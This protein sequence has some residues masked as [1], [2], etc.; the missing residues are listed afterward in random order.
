[1]SCY[2]FDLKKPV[3]I[4]IIIIFCQ[5]KFFKGDDNILNSFNYLYPNCIEL[6][7]GNFLIIFSD[8]VYIF[9]TDISEEINKIEYESGFSLNGGDDMNLINLAKFDDGIIIAIIKIYLY[10]FSSNGNYIHHIN[11]NDDINGAIYYSLIPIK[12]EE[13]NYYF[14]ITFMD[15]STKISIYYY[16]INISSNTYETIKYLQYSDSSNEMTNNMGLTCLLMKPSKTE[17]EIVCFYKVNGGLGATSFKFD[18]SINVSFNSVSLNY[19]NKGYYKSAANSDKTKALICRSNDGAGGYCI[20]YDITKNSFS[21]DIKYFNVCGNIPRGIHID[22]FE[23]TK[24]FIF[25]C[26]N[27]GIAISIIKFDSDGNVIG[28]KKL[29][30]ETNYYFIGTGLFSYTIIFLSKYSQYSILYSAN[31]VKSYHCLFSEEFKPSHI[32]GA[33]EDTDGNNFITEITLSELYIG[34][35]NF[36][37]QITENVPII[38]TTNIDSSFISEEAISTGYSDIKEAITENYS[39]NEPNNITSSF[40]SEIATSNKYSDIKKIVTENYSTDLL[41][42]NTSSPSSSSILEETTSI[43]YSNI[44]EI[45]TEKFSTNISTSITPSFISEEPSLINSV[46]IESDSRSSI[47]SKLTSKIIEVTDTDIINEQEECSKFLNGDIKCLYCNEESLKLNKC[48]ECNTE[49]GYYPISYKEKDE[50]YIECYNN[51]SKLNN[52][53][54]DSKSFML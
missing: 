27:T 37:T 4:V 38:K 42:N 17:K 13:N 20:I 33:N 36:I 44:K 25:S 1:M 46:Q 34:N 16:K 15:S 50:K 3:A 52:F 7:N 9:N 6:N 21:D 47:K 14:A 22:Y 12:Y 28:E 23:E 45:M 32:Y 41:T 26:T 35:S 8:G 18:D 51:Q 5:I 49:L 54:F 48:I 30:E 2:F 11:L 31:T 19:G 24:E 40:I 43:G 29:I 39:T 10:I 53:Y